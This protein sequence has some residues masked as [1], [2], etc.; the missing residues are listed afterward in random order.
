MSEIEIVKQLREGQNKYTYF[1]FSITIA[2]IAFA[3]NISSNLA[4]SYYHIPLGI[5]LLSW[6]YSIYSG[7]K[8][9]R[10]V[11]S[12]LYA[13]V[14]Y[15]RALRGEMQEIQSNPATQEPI[16]IG[17]TQA[18]ENNSEEGSKSSERQLKFF[19]IGALFFVI[20]H[21]LKMYL[22]TQ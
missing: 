19:F 10:L 13:N 15:L 21:V 1:I 17:I 16:I 11:H 9:I 20:W 14:H 4:L 18:M 12:T 6:S 2:S 7:F 3:I 5:A 8:Y 22:N